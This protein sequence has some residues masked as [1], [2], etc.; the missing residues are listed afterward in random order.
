MQ[1]ALEALPDLSNPDDSS[2]NKLLIPMFSEKVS[3]GSAH[4]QMTLTSKEVSKSNT[5]VNLIS[6]ASLSE[7]ERTTAV[8]D[9]DSAMCKMT[10]DSFDRM[11][12]DEI[13]D[14]KRQFKQS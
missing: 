10:D 12:E 6:S 11:E 5:N 2:D 4:V 9:L 7:C 8:D 13:E 3:N 14:D 1:E